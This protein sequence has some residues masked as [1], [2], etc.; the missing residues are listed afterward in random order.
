MANRTTRSLLGRTPG[1]KASGSIE[2]LG[3][4]LALEHLVALEA[5]EAHTER[6]GRAPQADIGEFASPPKLL[7][8]QAL[9][10][11][12]AHRKQYAPLPHAPL[13]I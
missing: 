10:R 1:V 4:R 3:R 7:L 8:R 2:K 13:S 5:C 11:R 9:E 6:L 12:R